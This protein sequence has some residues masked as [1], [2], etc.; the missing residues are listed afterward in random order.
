MEETRMLD[1]DHPNHT[2][3]PAE[4]QEIKNELERQR[5]IGR[6]A[7]LVDDE[8]E[9]LGLE[10]PEPNYRGMHNADLAETSFIGD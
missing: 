2:L 6:Q 10:L 7:I 1:P 8:D 3:T 5:A 4:M 9:D